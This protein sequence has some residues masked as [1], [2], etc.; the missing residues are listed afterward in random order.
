M[1]AAKYKQAIHR[2][3]CPL[4]QFPVLDMSCLSNIIICQSQ[5]EGKEILLT[6]GTKE[7]G[8]FF[9]F[10]CIGRRG[11]KILPPR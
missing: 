1:M 9:F 11:W 7:D 6:R 3:Q 5:P 10:F 8:R 4:S 2:L